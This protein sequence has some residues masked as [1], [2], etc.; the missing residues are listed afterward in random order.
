MTKMFNIPSDSEHIERYNVLGQRM[1][2]LR[3]SIRIGILLYLIDVGEAYQQQLN[4]H[5]ELAIEQTSMSRHLRILLENNLLNSERRGNR[6]Y[7]RR[8]EEGIKAWKDALCQVL[9]P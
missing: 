1:N 8:N 2:I 7:Y 6:I 3:D 9:G 4:D 5:F